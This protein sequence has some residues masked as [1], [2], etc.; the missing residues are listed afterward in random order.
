MKQ[1]VPPAK[2]AFIGVG[3]M[4]GP[5]ARRLVG[6]GYAVAVYDAFPSAMEKF[7]DQPCRIAS[8][9]ADAA[10]GV[11][12]VIT[13]LPAGDDVRTALFGPEGVCRTM[14]PGTIVM[15]MSTIDAA[16]TQAFAAELGRAG[17]AMLDCPVARTPEHARAGTLLALAGGDNDVIGAVTPVLDCFCERI[18]HVGRQGAGIRLKLINNYMSM[19]G[20]VLVAEGLTMA[21]KAGLD[22][23]QVVEMLSMTPAG[24]GQLTTNYAR[25]ALA[26]DITPDFPIR[27]G[28]KDISLGLSL[29][30]Q[31]SSPLFLGAAAREIFSL[32]AAWQR[33]DQDCTAL[34]HLLADL[35]RTVHKEPAAI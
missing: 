26:G 1:I 20:M 15:D 33:A 23:K 6:K 29:G 12:L 27:M 21:A 2:I 9:S 11:D 24:R 34:M 28:L 4:G 30:S 32:A 18:F 10:N 35:G 5:M 3:T 22:R 25:K 31:L 17:F 16:E 19:V 8:S 13:M 7:R 14:A